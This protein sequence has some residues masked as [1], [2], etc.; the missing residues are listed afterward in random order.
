MRRFDGGLLRQERIAQH[1]TPERLAVAI[2]RSATTIHAYERGRVTP[3]SPALGAL[4]D[5]LGVSL[6][7]LFTRVAA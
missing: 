7:S 2:G 5:A 3:S 1:L 6:D 4:A